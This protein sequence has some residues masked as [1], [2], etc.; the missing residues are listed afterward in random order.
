[1]HRKNKLSLDKIEQLKELG[2]N[3]KNGMDTQR[4]KKFRMAKEAVDNGFVVTYLN[5]DYKGI[6]L[7]NWIKWN[8]KNRSNKLMDDEISVIEKLTGKSISNLFN[9]NKPIY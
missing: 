7:Y 8:V 9:Y 4:E 5:Q 1:M 2:V 6:N 3:L